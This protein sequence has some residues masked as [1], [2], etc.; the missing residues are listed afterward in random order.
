MSEPDP[1]AVWA[2]HADSVAE[3][4]AEVGVH[5]DKVPLGLLL[6]PALFFYMDLAFVY[7]Q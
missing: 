7:D 4:L 1:L 6:L 3:R 5:T 2:V